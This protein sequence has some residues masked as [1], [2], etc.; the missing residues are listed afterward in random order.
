MLSAYRI[1]SDIFSF[2]KEELAGE[3]INFVS[4][5]AE[6]RKQT[7]VEV[8]QQLADEAV[9]TYMEVVSVLARR[10]EAL[11]AFQNFARGYVYFHIAN[12]RYKITKLW[13]TG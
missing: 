3:S 8:L 10:P 2:Y 1:W 9:E 6:S 11:E 13:A 7:K 4:T 12:K 5:M